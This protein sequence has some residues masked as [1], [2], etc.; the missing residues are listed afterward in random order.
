MR[1]FIHNDA[2]AVATCK[3]CGKAMCAKCSAYSSHSGICPECRKDEFIAERSR[4]NARTAEN[5]RSIFWNRVK[6]FLI[7][8]IPVMLYRNHNLKKENADAEARVAYLTA[9]IDKLQAALE[10]RGTA[11]FI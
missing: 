8:P 10:M 7:L 11:S 9:E 4:L 3:R 5:K 6:M 1:C 2:E